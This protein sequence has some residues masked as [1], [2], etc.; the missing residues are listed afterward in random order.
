MLGKRRLACVRRLLT[1]DGLVLRVL[2][3]RPLGRAAAPL[4][5]YL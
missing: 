2:L 1:A 3:D 4:Q 5:R